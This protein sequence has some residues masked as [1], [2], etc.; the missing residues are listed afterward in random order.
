MSEAKTEV[1]A[2]VE[3]YFTESQ[4]AQRL[5]DRFEG[6]LE[7]ATATDFMAAII[8]SGVL[9]GVESL[10]EGKPALYGER[11]EGF[12]TYAA[13][14]FL[15]GANIGFIIESSADP[16]HITTLLQEV[17]IAADVIDLPEEG[18]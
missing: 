1:A 11:C 14:L 18:G 10:V 16:R 4:L 2:A 7:P 17:S 13:Q 5:V 15:F 3:Q 8:K 9:K 6:G 12:L